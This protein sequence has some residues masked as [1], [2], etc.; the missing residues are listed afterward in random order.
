VCG[1]GGPG[2]LQCLQ[3]HAAPYS[4][5]LLLKITKLTNALM[6]NKSHFARYVEVKTENLNLQ[7]SCRF[8]S[9]S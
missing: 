3:Y 8:S 2:T 6:G 1:A 4:L 5:V 7:V 9:L